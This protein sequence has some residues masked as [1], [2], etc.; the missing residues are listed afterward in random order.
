NPRQLASPCSCLTAISE[1]LNYDTVF[2]TASSF[3]KFF[4]RLDFPKNHLAKLR[5]LSCEELLCVQRSPRLSHSFLA[6]N[7]LFEFLVQLLQLRPG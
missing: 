4:D 1:A 7:K 2:I 5:L 3:W 6:L